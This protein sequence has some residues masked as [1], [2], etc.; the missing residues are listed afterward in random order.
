MYYN[1]PKIVRNNFKIL[2]FLSYFQVLSVGPTKI[3]IL[4]VL[5]HLSK[6]DENEFDEMEV[7]EKVLITPTSE[8]DT[9]E[10]KAQETPVTVTQVGL[11]LCLQF[12]RLGHEALGG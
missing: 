9:S 5:T 4:R 3:T 6:E 7:D 10:V 11:P 2:I 1:C 8:G 12:L